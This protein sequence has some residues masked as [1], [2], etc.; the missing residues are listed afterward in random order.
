MFNLELTIFTMIYIY[1]TTTLLDVMTAQI[2]GEVQCLDL[3]GE[4]L[5]RNM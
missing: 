3:C 5:S 2:L 4:S 1:T